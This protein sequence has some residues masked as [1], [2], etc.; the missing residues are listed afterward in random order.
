MISAESPGEISVGPC[1]TIIAIGTAG[2]AM[3][4]N[5]A[6]DVGHSA[7]SSIRASSRRSAEILAI[8]WSFFILAIT[9]ILPEIRHATDHVA[10]VI[11]VL[12]AKARSSGHKLHADSGLT[13]VS[14]NAISASVRRETAP[15]LAGA[16]VASFRFRVTP[17]VG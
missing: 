17:V 7:A 1:G 8:K 5:T 15:A 9:A 11:E 16:T 13:T 3:V 12:D 6:E 10:G 2:A 4:P 14:G